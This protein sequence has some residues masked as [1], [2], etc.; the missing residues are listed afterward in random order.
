MTRI[1]C[2]VNRCWIFSL[3]QDTTHRTTSALL[4]LCGHP[5]LEK[6]LAVDIHAAVHTRIAAKLILKPLQ[7]E[8]VTVLSG[9]G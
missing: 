5:V 4:I 8:V 9:L 6:T 7:N 3:T 2:V 1:R